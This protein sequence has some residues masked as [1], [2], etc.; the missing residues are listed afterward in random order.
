MAHI[1]LSAESDIVIHSEYRERDLVKQVPG[2]RWDG[3]EKVWRVPLSWGS[4][5]ALRGV[6]GEQLTVDE[7]LSQWAWADFKNRVEPASAARLALEEPELMASEPQLYPFQRSGVKFLELA[8]QALIADEMGS[9]KTIQLIRVIARGA[10]WLRDEESAFTHHGP[11]T[12]PA[13]IVCPNSMNFTWK[14]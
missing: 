5:I 7:N 12:L 4:C 14:A 1:T 11:G 2:T 10:E 3:E 6:F 13:L 9:G 8:K